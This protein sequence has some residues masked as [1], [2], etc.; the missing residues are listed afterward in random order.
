MILLGRF[1]YRPMLTVGLGAVLSQW[2][3]E[4][5][6]PVAFRI[7]KVDSGRNHLFQM[8]R[9]RQGYIRREEV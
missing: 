9:R 8:T 5:D 6:R 3:D 4:L 7:K 2:V 1:C